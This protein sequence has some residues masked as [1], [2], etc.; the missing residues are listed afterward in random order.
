MPT[1]TTGRGLPDW[2]QGTVSVTNGSTSVTFSGAGLITTNATTGVDEYAAGR[3]DILVAN[4]AF[5]IIASVTGTNAITLASAWTGVTFS[6]AYAIIRYSIPA[7]GSIAK[8]L[9]D[10]LNLGT[11][12]LPDLSRTFDDNTARLKIKAASSKMGLYGGATGTADGSLLKHL[13]FN[14]TTGMVDAS[15]GL[16]IKG[17]AV[18]SIIP[19]MF[20]NRAPNPLQEIWQR[21]PGGS[22]SC[23]SGASRYVGPDR[24]RIY[25]GAGVAVAVA[26]VSAPTGF[27]GRYATQLSAT[28]PSSAAWCFF[29][30]ALE[31]ANA[32]DLYGKDIVVSFNVVV[33]STSG[34]PYVY[35][36]VYGTNSSWSSFTALTANNV[37]ALD[38]TTGSAY[39]T[40][41]Q[42]VTHR[43][44]LRIPAATMTNSAVKNGLYINIVCYSPSGNPTVTIG[45]I[46]IEAAQSA[47]VFEPPPS[48]AVM[49]DCLRYYE[50]SY[51]AS[52]A[53]GSVQSTGASFMYISG[54]ASAQYSG[55]GSVLFKAAKYSVPTMTLYSLTSG[56]SGKARDYTNTADVTASLLNGAAADSGF[57]W[58]AQMAGAGTQISMGTHW[59]AESEILSIS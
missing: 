43:Y 54:L 30:T 34:Q 3:G 9:Q 26:K 13:E 6:G 20:K 56:A 58:Y 4:G 44:E 50:K 38:G 40:P 32:Q 16:S 10:L 14:P 36:N 49:Q 7:S 42:G 17:N 8:S 47:T 55:S 24:Y 12:T 45:D 23:P 2:T 33:Q 53:P 19:G 51:P 5:A 21:A 29:D 22:A 37:H 59:T 39:S 1:I 48:W 18:P 31:A 35:A 41:S 27:V 15:N 57:T 11:D 28:S 46:Q 25:A 52:V